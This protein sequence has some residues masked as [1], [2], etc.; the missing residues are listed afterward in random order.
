MNINI[1]HLGLLCLSLFVITSNYCQQRTWKASFDNTTSLAVTGRGTSTQ[2][3]G[4]LQTQDAYVSLGDST[5]RNYTVSFRARSIDTANN[6]QIWAGFRAYNRNDRYIV[7]LRGGRQNNLYLSRLGYMGTDEFLA[8]RTLDFHPEPNKWYNIRIAVCDN[9][10]RVYLNDED[11]PRIDV[12]DKNSRLAPAGSVTLGGGWLKTEY[13]DVVVK[14]LKESEWRDESKKEYVVALSAEDKEQM[15]RKQRGNYTPVVV[16]ALSK[17]RTTVS[18]NGNWLF[19][20]TYELAD[21]EKAVSPETNDKQWHTM[22]VPDFWNPIRIWLHGE[23]F[24]GY[25]K[26]ASDAYFQNETARCQNYTFDYKKTG[27]AWYRQWI[28]L[29]AGIEQ[30]ETELSFDAI[31]K[32]AE[33]YINGKLAGKHIGMFGEF[34]VNGKGLFKAGKNLVTVKVVRDYVSDIKDAGKIVDVAVSVEV[35]NK[36]LKDLAHGFYND[37][38][39]GI[40]QPVSLVITEPLKIKDVYIQPGL[41]G[42]DFDITVKN[43][44]AT[45]QVFS[46]QTNIG[47]KSGQLYKGAALQQS[48]IKVGEEK[49]FHYTIDQLKPKLWSPQEPN[50][51]DF[52]FAIQQNGQLADSTTI[53]SGFRTFEVKEGLFYLNGRKYWLRGGNHTP[54]ALA[55]NDTELAEKFYDLMKAGNMEV[56]RTHTAPYNENWIAAADRKGVGIS[57]EGTWPWLM[58]TTSM[59]DQ[60]LIELWADEFIDLLKKY[61]NHPSVL[62]WTV[63]NEMKFYDNDPDFERAKIKMRI[64]SEVVKRM[65][66]ADKTRPI[67]FDSNY[68]RDEKK[69]G[70]D[71]FKDIDDGD[72]DDIHAY[73]NWYDYS[74]FSQFNGEFQKRNKNTGRPLISQEM[75]SGYPN[76]ETGHPTRFYTQV[77]QTPQELVGELAYE[78]SNPAYFLEAQAF[79]TGEQ[80][81]AYRRSNDQASGIL[82]FALLT[83]FRNVY[84]SKAIQPYPTYY[85]LQRALQPV[86]VSAELYGRHFYAG[87]KIATRICVVNDRH[88]GTTLEAPTV[89]WQLL[90][91]KGAVLASGKQIAADVPYYGRVWVTPEIVIPASLQAER[92]NA[93]L[94]VTLSEKGKQVSA[95]EYKIVLANKKYVTGTTANIVLVDGQNNMKPAFD[96][97]GAKYTTA[98]NITDALKAA[99]KVMVLAGLQAGKNCSEEDV[100]ALQAAIANGKRILLLDAAGI[101]QQLFPAAI[102]GTQSFKEGDIVNMDVPESGVFS[103]LDKLDLRYFNNNVRELP[104]VCSTALSVNRGKGVEILAKHISVHGYIKGEMD[105]RAVYMQKIQGATIVK[106]NENVLLSTMLLDKAATDPVAGKLLSNMINELTK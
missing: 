85:A 99:G 72:I 60:K 51:Y 28:E 4:T 13:T 54:Y 82:H 76:N 39:A 41:T 104:A 86:L 48:I 100:K 56:T 14:S 20:P 22:H 11:L 43:T 45:D 95:N 7:A 59:P 52:N 68:K 97:L 77:H 63:N 5:W 106:L 67:S 33:V 74:I 55:P 10:I 24:G 47:G 105:E 98:A 36:M 29:P 70:K 15:R 101:A 81:E 18:L 37:D 91:D 80:A 83:W 2:Q 94:V 96:K 50:L 30:K 75:S 71:F 89:N 78:Y 40:W 6:V 66:K 42:A 23:T 64:I 88:E 31:S 44:T 102:S 19:M 9:R 87:E 25:T 1:K 73:I 27:A 34:K 61:R 93:K 38:P 57:F 62:F 12:V 58:I 8:L 79:I 17:T 84:D 92:V 53:V 26:G 16:N 69:F 21:Q 103:G 49:V 35:T 32:V 46:V 3:Q 65:R 90:T